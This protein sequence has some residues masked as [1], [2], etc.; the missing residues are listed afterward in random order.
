MQHL[1]HFKGTKV[2]LTLNISRLEVRAGY[3]AQTPP[4]L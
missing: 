4:T 1:G 2:M 3:G